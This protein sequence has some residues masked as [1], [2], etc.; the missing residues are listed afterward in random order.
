MLLAGDI[1]G[2][3]TFLALFDAQSGLTAAVAEKSYPSGA[4]DSLEAVVEDFLR[5]REKPVARAS[6]GVAGP[7]VDGTAR[8]SN[9]PW[10]V[11]E[12]SLRRQFGFPAVSVLND[13]EAIAH[14]VTVLQGSDL[15]C[16][17]EGD[18]VPRGNI[19]VIAPGTGL[20]E[21]FLTWD[22]GA[23]RAHASEGG[24]GDFAPVDSFQLG[25]LEHLLER[26]GHVSCERVCSGSGIPNIYAYIREKGLAEEPDWLS[27]ELRGAADPTAVIMSAAGEGERACRICRMTAERFVAILA[28][29]AGNMAL[30]NV[31]AAG[32][33]LGGGIPPR[34]IS[35]LRKPAF[36][37][38][39]TGK[40]RMTRL[41]ERVPVWV[42]VNTRAPL[43]GAACF[44]LQSVRQRSG[45]RSGDVDQARFVFE[46]VLG[47]ANHLGLYSEELGPCGEHLGNFPQ[48]F[49]HLGL[50]SAAYTL[51]RML[52]ASGRPS[53]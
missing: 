24:H 52:T 32:V 5:E 51:D 22:G 34:M 3:K 31:A 2:T 21:A 50:I 37:E 47:Y 7:V 48:A 29:E 45:H 13:L 53:S 42:I 49:T 36:R 27:R 26:F 20:G 38:R 4:Y 41:L 6:F 28:A 44:G 11:K 33:Y 40:G 9:L 19:A 14:S 46:K 8:L 30:R 16:V 10:V 43:L 17:N 25:L 18:F 1:G 12:S 15:A 35:F 23:Y 39:F